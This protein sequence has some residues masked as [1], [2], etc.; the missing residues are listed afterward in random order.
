MRYRLLTISVLFAMGPF[1]WSGETVHAV[2]T[3]NVNISRGA[4]ALMAGRN[5]EGIRLTLRGLDE[6]ISTKEKEVALSNLCAGYTNKGDFESALKYCDMVLEQ[7]DQV[8]QAHNSKALIY[9]YTGQYE[10]AEE[11]LRL[12][13]AIEPDARTMK[14]A[15]A[16]Y[17]EATNPVAPV[18]EIDDR[19]QRDP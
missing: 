7:N 9:I 2:G 6:A 10:K 19:Q 3:S 15:R 13:E 11:S 4:D 1:A 17:E 5:E 12:G 18:I 8:W 16:L 14:V